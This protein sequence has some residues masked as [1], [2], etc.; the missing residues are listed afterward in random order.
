MRPQHWL[1]TIPLR[2]RSLFRR[3]HV[4]QELSE[5]LQFHVEK[6]TQEYVNAGLSAVEARRRALREFGGIEQS[7]ENSRDARRVNLIEDFLQDLRYAGRLL[8]RSPG[9]AVVAVLT[10]ALGIGANTAIFGMVNAVLLGPLPYQEPD[11]LIYFYTGDPKRGFDDHI[12]V[13]DFLDWKRQNHVF[14]NLA[15]YQGAFFTLTGVSEPQRF[16]GTFITA[17][18]LPT[19]GVN[20]ALGRNFLPEEQNPG[21]DA[22]V[23]LSNGFWTHRLSADPNVLGKKLTLNGQPFTVVGILPAALRFSN[24]LY[25]NADIFAPFV[26]A[27]S[28]SDRTILNRT[29]ALARLKPGVTLQQAQAEME[30]IAETLQ[31][32]HADTNRYRGVMI[33]TMAEEAADVQ[34]TPR[35]MHQ[36]LWVMLGA[37]GF[38]ML[39]ACANV[40]SLL[41]A[42]G[43]T[44]Q[45]E[46]VMRIAIGSSR[47]RMIRQLLTECVTL[48][49]CGGAGGLAIAEWSKVLIAKTMNAYLEDRTLTLDSRV[50]LFC[51]GVSLLTGL[52]FGLAPAIQTVKVNLQ[53]AMRESGG[54]S[55]GGWRRNRV[56]STLVVL[57]LSLATILLIGFGLVTRSFLHVLDSS[58]GFDPTN[59]LTMYGNLDQQKYGS[60]PQ[61][62]AFIHKTLDEVRQLPGVQSAG[63]ADSIPLMGADVTRFSIEDE[64]SLIPREHGTEVRIVTVTPGF[65]Q[66]LGIALRYG[67][68]FD[69][70]DSETAPGL[71]IVNE[72]FARRYF[73]GQTPLGKRLKLEDS[74]NGWSEIVGV[75]SDVRQRNMDE[76]I[77]PIVYRSWYQLARSSDLTV[78]VRVTASADL[79]NIGD[80][81]RSKLRTLDKDQVWGPVMTMQQV[82]DESESVSMRRP[83]VVLLGMF[84]ALALVLAVVGIYGVLSYSVAERTKEIGIR[85]A[86]GAQASTILKM[87]LRETLALIGVGL[88]AGILVALA[89]TSFLPTGPI[90]WTGA[91][92]HLYGI[93]RIDAV[94]YCGVSLIL[95]SIALLASYLPAY[96]ATKVDPL[97]ALHYE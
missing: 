60:P 73:P 93:S 68:G 11:R 39:M 21:S 84:G 58:P 74:P 24:P 32:E 55:S 78:A 96:R 7:K 64:Q 54:T 69:E 72:T 88:S 44:R 10:L 48:F 25:A 57:E 62:V 20:I 29:H 79:K 22:V 71:A 50:F 41:L 40:A 37:V 15:A 81:L 19:L 92:I 91:A 87:V 13:A 35:R 67:R 17:N 49:L 26:L 90:G 83:V 16:F 45:R 89:L 53:D 70:H 18:W 8:H 85:A 76:D 36:S 56:R 94:T 27:N 34:P 31:S 46:F 63:I 97:I 28:S 33:R 82:I 61:R 6:K 59:V 23:I 95:T 38:V 47:S 42:R 3:S 5:E 12:S 4:E 77:V 80:R 66:T 30:A 75:I 86:L 14:E 65:F 43:S 51:L 1:Y 52:L 2:L 9:L